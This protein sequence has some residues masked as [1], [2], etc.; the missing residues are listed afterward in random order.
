MT[1]LPWEVGIIL[2]PFICG[3]LAFVGG[4]RCGRWF[5]GASVLM[6]GAGLSALAQELWQ[7]GPHVY[8][9]GGWGAPL[10][11]ELYADGLS[12]L[13]L[14]L[15]ALVVLL[16][17]IFSLGLIKAS[18]VDAEGCENSLF[19]PLVLFFWGSLN[20]LFLSRDVFNLY[21]TL[22]LLTLST[23]PLITLRG[24]A[25]ALAAGLRY[26]F[27]ALIGSL[28]Y[29]LGTALLYAVSG[30]LALHAL[31]EST[32][33]MGSLSVAAA[34]MVLGLLLKTALFPL[35]FW[36]PA[37]YAEAPSP[38]SALLAALATKASFY[39]VLRL[40]F[41]LFSFGQEF[42]A[43]Q[44][45][46]VLGMLAMLWGSL[47]AWRQGRVKRLLA[48]SS[49]AQIGYLFLVFPLMA[50]WTPAGTGLSLE[51]PGA[52][53]GLIFLILSHG[54]AKSAMFM[55]A[56]CLAH[57]AGSD[58]IADLTGVGRQ[59]PVPLFAFALGGMTLMGLPP[60]GGFSSKWLFLKAAVESLQWWWVPGMLLGGVLA[61][62]YVFR[63]LRQAL[64]WDA[65]GGLSR[66]VP[67]RMQWTAMAT[68]LLSLALGLCGSWPLNLLAVGYP[69]GP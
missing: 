38:V 28:A 10:G 19:W 5:F 34:L 11:I 51:V 48:Y 55:S 21:V 13:M 17:G 8:A 50:T 57:A 64:V 52:W 33:N 56:G 61:A 67:R 9:V 4:K 6:V 46:G 30:S 1:T 23:V 2:A 62:G 53:G 69:G 58:Q 25:S 39:L 54:L 37:A 63:V 47:L 15:T 49:I 68:A 40:W 22:E 27:V 18:P 3:L 14:L 16:V 26:L 24:T 59:L 7:Y 32:D 60:S 65:D 44:F 41:E 29:L 31:P 35:H 36:L 45:L 12:L 20:A 66:S 43:A 42:A